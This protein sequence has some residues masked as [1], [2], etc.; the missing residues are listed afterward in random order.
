MLAC[1]SADFPV[2]HFTPGMTHDVLRSDLELATRLR[3]DNRPDDEIIL[4]LV[5][6]GV[7]PGL[8]ALVLDDLRNGRKASAR[9]AL[10]AEFGVAR[11]S[12]TRR[13]S[14]RSGQSQPSR[15]PEAESPSEPP[16]PPSEP[17][18]RR[19]PRRPVAASG[20][21]RSPVFWL[22]A[23]IVVA[24]VIAGGVFALSR[25]NPA[26]TNAP[27]DQPLP[28]AA[29]KVPPPPR[30]A[31]AKVATASQNVPSTTL[32]LELRPDGLHLGGTLVTRDNLLTAVANLLGA[33]SRTNQAKQTGT[34]I[35]A[36]DHE[37]LLIYSQPGGGA[38][39]IVLD[40]E[41]SG[42]THG[43]TSPFAGALAIDGQMIRADTDAPTL[44]AIK[45]LGLSHPGSHSG[46]WGG[47]YNNLELVFAYLKSPRRL[48]LI[49]IDLK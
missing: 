26:T 2:K 39:S 16:P 36:Y 46:I 40:C 18:P 44:T 45:Q 31:S 30:E 42:G 43:S 9:L 13:G 22:I 8:A 6:R 47:R 14:R 24:L 12:R 23:A 38:N 19:E 21:K 5:H 41:A 25:R 11:R 15:S 29:A 7:D 10:P 28:V 4:A 3:D 48:S 37:G 34:L 27:E 33:A 32:A 1:I 35:Y 49:E 17:V 20:G